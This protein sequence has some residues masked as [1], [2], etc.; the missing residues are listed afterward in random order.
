MHRCPQTGHERGRIP[1]ED[2]MKTI[3]IRD[4]MGHRVELGHIPDED[5]ELASGVID[6]LAITGEAVTPLLAAQ[7]RG[8]LA[9][10]GI[11][12]ADQ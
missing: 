4:P 6:S 3:D 7:L 8:F 12:L 11:R 5:V 9:Q 10:S 2:T 1:E